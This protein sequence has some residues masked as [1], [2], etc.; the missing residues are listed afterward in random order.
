MISHHDYDYNDASCSVAN[1]N[2]ET[3][4]TVVATAGDTNTVLCVVLP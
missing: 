2:V 3:V 4:A 1:W